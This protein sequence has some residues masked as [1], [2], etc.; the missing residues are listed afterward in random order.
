MSTTE[1]LLTVIAA[2]VAIMAIIQVA[3]AIIAAKAARRASRFMEGFEKDV[4]P[5]VANLQTM[6]A[7]AARATALATS[8][9]DRAD[10]MLNTLAKHIDEAVVAIQDLVVQPARDGLAVLQGLKAAFASFREPP[11]GDTKKKGDD[12]EDLFIG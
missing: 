1:I 10:R 6:S 9:I 11:R 7:D 5:I 12:E 3:A 8:Q 2:A 4:R